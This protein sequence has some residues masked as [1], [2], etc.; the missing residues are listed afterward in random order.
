MQK[1]RRVGRTHHPVL[2]ASRRAGHRDRRW[3][4]HLG[5]A[6][7]DFRRRIAS[8]VRPPQAKD[9]RRRPAL[10]ARG[11]TRRWTPISRIAT[12]AIGLMQGRAATR[13]RGGASHRCAGKLEVLAQ[14][15]AFD[16][17][18]R[19]QLS[20]AI[21]EQEQRLDAAGDGC[22]QLEPDA[23]AAAHGLPAVRCAAEFIARRSLSRRAVCPRLAETQRRCLHACRRVSVRGSMRQV[24]R[25]GDER[26]TL[27]ESPAARRTAQ[28]SAKPSRGCSP[29]SW[30]RRTSAGASWWAGC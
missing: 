9:A 30:K 13:W 7:E 10:H 18:A 22:A 15:G 5:A 4:R 3:S 16:A 14:Q 1:G 24:A 12:S 25:R 2:G 11:V 20:A 6:C 26:S 8:R 29:R 19:T 21:A 23:A 27:A 28:A 17:D